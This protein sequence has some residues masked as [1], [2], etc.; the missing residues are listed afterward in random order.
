ML[1]HGKL[2][3]HFWGHAIL[4][5]TTL[6]RLRPSLLNSQTTLEVVSGT[7]PSIAHLK[8]FGCK[9]WVPISEPKQKTIS[10]HRIH[11]T[12]LGFDS[13]SVIR[14]K[15]PK[16]E[17]VYKARHHNCKVIKYKFPEGLSKNEPVNF[18][19]IKTLIKNHDLRTT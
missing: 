2:P 9:V 13:P 16:K 18:K 8:V 17:E 5:A 14:Y 3:P 6:L 4:H 15:L 12:Y 11:A 10:S 1:L 7:T 19:D